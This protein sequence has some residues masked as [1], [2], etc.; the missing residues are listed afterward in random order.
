MWGVADHR[1]RRA[2]GLSSR[3]EKI[4][5]RLTLC[6]PR[7]KKNRLVGVMSL[8][9]GGCGDGNSGEDDSD[10]F[11]YTQERLVLSDNQGDD[12]RFGA[13][14][15]EKAEFSSCR[16]RME[17]GS[18]VHRTPCRVPLTGSG[19]RA[20]GPG[21]C[22]ACSS[23]REPLT[24]GGPRRGSP[25]MRPRVPRAH[26]RGWHMGREWQLGRGPAAPVEGADLIIVC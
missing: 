10:D 25:I 7:T 11:S 17:S 23:I 8:E 2:L 4:P 21:R 3:S 26:S 9:G 14:R 20:S 12:E 18:D 16:L 19:L 15:A 22:T 1:F 24:A 5:R 6:E 13:I